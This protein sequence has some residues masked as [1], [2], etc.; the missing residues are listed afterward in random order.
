MLPG[1]ATADLAPAEQRDTLLAQYAPA[2]TV[3][4]LAR[5][6]C[7]CD[8][9]GRRSEDDRELRSKYR[10][11]EA[12]RSDVIEALDQHRRVG[13]RLRYPVD[14]PGALAGFVAEHARNA[15]GALYYLRFSARPGSAFG[16]PDVSTTTIGALEVRSA[17]T[18]WLP[19]ERPIL[20]LP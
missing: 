11:V 12:A 7:A 18:S 9:V 4:V 19:E 3:V 13:S 10:A 16:W 20:V 5:G 6:G 8:L 1:G 2:Q 14:W 17:P 15:G